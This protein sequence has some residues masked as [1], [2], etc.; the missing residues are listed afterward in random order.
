MAQEKTN[1]ILDNM[2]SNPKTKNFLNHLINAYYPVS[3]VDKVWQK[4][5]GQFKCVLTNQNLISVQEI[6][7][8][9][10][11]EEFKNNFIE[12][13]KIISDDSIKKESPMAKLIGDKKLGFTGKNTTTFMSLS[14]LEEFHN[15]LIVKILNND[16]HIMWV[17]GSNKKQQ[18]Q[19]PEKKETQAS[20]FTLGELDSFKSLYNKF[21]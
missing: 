13:L 18:K 4:P 14:S 7:D 21:K 17:L 9:I 16:K 8:G 19:K 15:W 6:M 11:S 20:T 1:E 5:E 10:Q 12:S 3:N 2:L